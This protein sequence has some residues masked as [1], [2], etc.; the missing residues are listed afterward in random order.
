MAAVISLRTVRI[1]ALA[2]IDGI[3]FEPRP[4]RVNHPG[5]RRESRR[6]PAGLA[7]G[8]GVVAADEGDHFVAGESFD[9]CREVGL[10]GFLV[11]V[12][13]VL[14]SPRRSLFASSCSARLEDVVHE[15]DD[16]VVV[17]E[18]RVGSRSSAD[19]FVLESN[20]CAGA[21]KRPSE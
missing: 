7:D 3:R 12:A 15:G 10:H 17:V 19:V 16:H 13:I 14:T 8:V 1:L 2:G 11:E 20:D 5:R 6:P 4:R 9:G 21:H 18:G